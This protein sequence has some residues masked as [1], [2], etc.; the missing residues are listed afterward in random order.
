[1]NGLPCPREASCSSASVPHEDDG[2]NPNHK[3]PGAVSR[4]TSLVQPT[5]APIKKPIS[6]KPEIGAHFVSFN[7][8]NPLIWGQVSS[9]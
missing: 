8:K 5:C 7:F 1:M 9:G 3:K 4:I 2:R 6:G